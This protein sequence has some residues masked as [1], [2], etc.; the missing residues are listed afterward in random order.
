MK[1]SL[2]R[3]LLF[4]IT[5]PI[6]GAISNAQVRHFELGFGSTLPQGWTADG[7][8]MTS[9]ASNRNTTYEETFGGT[10]AV[11]ILKPCTITTKGYYTAGTL[12]FWL[13]SKDTGVDSLVVEKSADGG[14]T[15]TKLLSVVSDDVFPYTNYSVDINDD[16]PSV[17]LRFSSSDAKEFYMDDLYLTTSQPLS[18]DNAYLL[19]LHV[20]EMPLPGFEPGVLQYEQALTY[21]EASVQAV[22]F[23]PEASFQVNLPEPNDFFGSDAERTGTVEVTS[24]DGSQTQSYEI[25]FNVDGYHLRYG[26]PQSGGGAIPAKWS[27]SGSY[28]APGI[29]NDLYNGPNAIRFTTLDGSLVTEHYKG[30]DTVMFYTKVEMNDGSAIQAGEILTMS[31]KGPGDADWTEIGSFTTDSEISAD[32]QQK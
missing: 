1:L 14:N 18:D 12:S 32:W 27:T 29:S 20:N 21:P 2:L 24:K 26:F 8:F 5:L 23:H 9:T 22:T 19:E 13:M 16:S 31:T 17:K 15:W 4:T 6:A 28:T 11:K 30:V 7:V 10:H 25:L 3:T